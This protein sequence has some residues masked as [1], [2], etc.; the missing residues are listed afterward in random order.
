MSGQ[1]LRFHNFFAPTCFIL[2]IPDS[3]T[4]TN[5]DILTLTVQATAFMPKLKKLW[6]QPV[7][8]PTIVLINS[9]KKKKYPVLSK[10][11]TIT[12]IQFSVYPR[13]QSQA[14]TVIVTIQLKV[15]S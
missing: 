13:S 14:D 9:K 1:Q 10:S 15:V 11:S 3:D 6:K 2:G 7:I 4:I 5:Y 12:F 8:F